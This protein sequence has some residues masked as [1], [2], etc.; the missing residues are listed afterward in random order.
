MTNLLRD[1][2]L[3]FLAA[4]NVNPDTMTEQDF[5]TWLWRYMT[6]PS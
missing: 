2:F 1:P 3:E 4:H 5:W 6:S